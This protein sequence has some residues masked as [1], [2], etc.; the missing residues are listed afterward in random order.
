MSAG[1][2]KK[3]NIYSILSQEII[4][5]E[6]LVQ[7]I[8]T[9]E[10]SGHG[11]KQFT[12][13]ADTDDDLRAWVD[14][15]RGCRYEDIRTARNQIDRKYDH[16]TKIM[17]NE[18]IEKKQ[19]RQLCQNQEMEIR[20]LKGEM[21]CLRCELKLSTQNEP[22]ELQKIKKIQSFI[23]G[24]LC[25]R[26]WK[27]IVQNYV[28]S[29]HSDIL[30]KRNGIFFQLYESERNY[31]QQM[32]ILVSC[33]LRPLKMAASS[34]KPSVTHD[35]VNSIFLN[36]ETILFLHQIILKILHSRIENWPT[37][38]IGNLLDV[39]LPTL[40]IYQE[41]VRNHH[42]S[43]QVLAECKIRP[44]FNKLLCQ[45]EQKPACLGA[46]LENYLTYPMHEVPNIIVTLHKLLA[47]TPP[48][49]VDRKSLENAQGVLN[50]IARVMQDEVSE[51]ESIRKNLSI[52]RRIVEGCDILLDVEQ[53]LL[54]QGPLIQVSLEK[55]K[56]VSTLKKKL[57][58]KTKFGDK[59]N[60]SIRLCFLFTKHLIITSHLQSGRLHIVKE[61]GKIQLSEAILEEEL[62]DDENDTS[63]QFKL[64]IN[65]SNSTPYSVVFAAATER[66]KAAWTTDIGQCIENLSSNQYSA[67]DS[68]PRFSLN[69]DPDLFE[70]NSDIRFSKVLNSYKVPQIRHASTTKLIQR[71]LDLRFLSVDYL[72]VFLLTHHVFTTSEH[73]IDEL[74]Q[75]YNSWKGN[76]NGIDKHN[77]EYISDNSAS[78]YGQVSFSSESPPTSPDEIALPTLHYVRN[79]TAGRRHS[80]DH[81]F[82]AQGYSDDK[83]FR[84]RLL[85]NPIPTTVK[86]SKQRKSPRRHQPDLMGNVNEY[87]TN[88]PPLASVL[89]M[90]TTTTS[91]PTSSVNSLTS[92][93]SSPLSRPNNLRLSIYNDKLES[94]MK[95]GSNKNNTSL[96]SVMKS[97]KSLNFSNKST[98]SKDSPTT[99]S[100]SS[101]SSGFGWRPWSKQSNDKS[102]KTTSPPDDKKS[103]INDT[104]SRDSNHKIKSHPN[105]PS[106]KSK[107]ALSSLK[108]TNLQLDISR[109]ASLPNVTA[110]NV[111]HVANPQMK[112]VQESD[113][114]KCPSP[115]PSSSH[116]EVTEQ[117]TRTS[118]GVVVTSSRDSLR[119]SSVPPAV[120]AFAVATSPVPA[121]KEKDSA[122]PKQKISRGRAPSFRDGMLRVLKIFKSW[123]SNQP[124]DLINDEVLKNRVI[125]F[126]TDAC[127]DASTIGLE[128]KLPK[129]MIKIMNSQDVSIY[130]TMS[131]EKRFNVTSDVEDTTLDEIPVLEMAEQ[132]CLLHYYIYAAIGSGELLQKSWMK[133][134]RD[135]KAPN[136]LRA[137]H[138]FNHTS[139]LVATEILNRSQPAAR[140]AV[141]EK[142][143]QIAN[144][145][146]CMNNFNTV[147]AIVAA[148]TNSSIHR[149]KK[150]WEKVSKQEKLIIK[151][152]EELASAD[153]RFKNV[154]EALRCCQPPC[155]PYL[156]LYLSD[157]TFMEEANPSETDDQL[158][159]FSKLR[160]IAHLIEEIRIYQGTPYRMRCLPK[161]MKYI[162]NAKPINCDKQLFELSLQ[163]EPRLT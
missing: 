110:Q 74:L 146:R 99:P 7:H 88:T 41:Y 38:Q 15:I 72:N 39:F 103:I 118:A 86:P 116:L 58:A 84:P 133:G 123:L 22:E 3:E 115:S 51:T 149:L 13:A 135:T 147:M 30:K 155:V 46:K 57:A 150:T 127:N 108:V 128:D 154:K 161:V 129:A 4:D 27:A 17:E 9:I 33:Y 114:S 36:C 24:W 19:L 77:F 21:H 137:I 130:A 101:S 120:A 106:T 138:Y 5:E 117:A 119:R 45:L 105:S 55:T 111:A 156:G 131:L 66:E 8:F 145:C 124:Q 60:P 163:L 29:E 54:R 107:S 14:N 35:E 158:I 122:P 151:R 81:I 25:R 49:H 92:A 12:F 148:L 43:L 69:S 34:K 109:R 132:M 52:E 78:F 157:L 56:D 126:L 59:N 6:K 79:D 140:A 87:L 10:L 67:E 2:G 91:T 152:L 20:N 89:G 136:V 50:E 44:T 31:V 23:R 32:S 83:A 37:L 102:E 16:L 11:Q 73:V 139:R 153:R 63:L 65:P 76:S 95:Q 68:T 1:L 61:C 141:I 40:A 144:N 28:S 80:S 113:P 48:G 90:V 64:T 85:T 75:F 47:F 70:D 112:D 71:L 94:A 159:N 62:D 134:D 82:Y 143:A 18:E 53:C 160:M 125:E 42:Y 142:W 100:S 121:R 104:R 26:K 96:S 162:L 98:S 97:S 93:S